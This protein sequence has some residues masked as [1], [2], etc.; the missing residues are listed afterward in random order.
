[1]SK[2][3]N[4]RQHLSAIIYDKRG[5][6]ISVGVNS[7]IKTHPI[8]ARHAK[9]VGEEHKVFLHAEIHAISRCKTL[10]QAHKIVVIRWNKKGEPMYARPCP[11][12]M[13]A[14]KEAGIKEIEH[15]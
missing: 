7:Y 12:C 14:I 3:V 5:R 15:T 4:A 2:P 9:L 13:S 6:V 10:E 8:Q 1:M 11:I